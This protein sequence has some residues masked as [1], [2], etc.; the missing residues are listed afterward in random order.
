[1]R[2]GNWF[3]KNKRVILVLV[4]IFCTVIF[5]PKAYEYRQYRNGII[6]YDHRAY[7]IGVVQSRDAALAYGFGDTVA[8][9]VYIFGNQ[10]YDLPDNPYA[11]TLIFLKTKNGEIIL[12][13]LKGGP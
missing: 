2:V 8:T 10:V 9:G 5:L 12:C 3:Q 6:S 1:M 4:L 13:S 7:T 11:S